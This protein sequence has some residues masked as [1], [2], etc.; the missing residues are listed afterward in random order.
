MNL[1]R[2]RPKDLQSRLRSASGD[3]RDLIPELSKDARSKGAEISKEIARQYKK[4]DVSW[5]RGTSAGLVRGGILAGILAPLLYLYVKH[6]V[7]GR[8][9]LSEKM[10]DPVIFVA[11]HSSHLDTP[12]ILRAIPPEWRKRTAVAAAAD[13]FYK[14]RWRAWSAALVFNTVPMGRTGGGLNSGASD[15]VHELIEEGWNLLIFP[16]GTRSRDGEIGKVKS[17][18]AVLA[19]QHG[20]NLVPIWVGGTHAAMPPGQ[21][22]PKRLQGRF[23]SRRVKVEVRFGSPIPP[24]DSA[25]RHEVMA[26]VREFWEREG[27]PESGEEA[28]SAREILTMQAAK[29]PHER[30]MAEDGEPAKG[31]AA[32]D[33]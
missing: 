20:L 21:N 5:A 23:F 16:E 28:P 22:W 1:R 6:R 19:A 33:V 3:V 29:R 2:K 30:R 12:T 27:R 10:T 8:E 31:D 24:R 11:N 18:A 32:P 13:Y 14:S 17:G 25:D 15:H 4:M 26:H 7:D 9:V